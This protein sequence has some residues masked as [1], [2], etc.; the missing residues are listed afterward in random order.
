MTKTK[1][2]HNL[3][4]NLFLLGGGTAM[5]DK[6]PYQIATE[7]LA[8]P[9]I[10]TGKAEKPKETKLGEDTLFQNDTLPIPEIR[11]PKTERKNERA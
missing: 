9:E 6:N 5:K 7:N 10:H 4:C 1:P 3:F 2:L 11:L 8:V